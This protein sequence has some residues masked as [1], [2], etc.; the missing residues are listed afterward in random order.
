MVVLHESV[1]ETWKG[2]SLESVAAGSPQVQP[3]VGQ[4]ERADEVIMWSSPVYNVRHVPGLGTRCRPPKRTLVI[5]R[6]SGS[7]ANEV[8]PAF[9]RHFS[10]AFSNAIGQS[11]FSLRSDPFESSNSLAVPPQVPLFARTAFSSW[12]QADRNKSFAVLDS[13]ADSPLRPFSTASREF[14]FSATEAVGREASHG[15]A[16]RAAHSES[17]LLTSFEDVATL[18]ISHAAVERLQQIWA[19]R[20]FERKEGGRRI[21]EERGG[22]VLGLL[23]RVVSGG[24][25]GYKY[26]F[27]LVGPD[28][29]SALREGGEHVFFWPSFTSASGSAADPGPSTIR[30][31]GSSAVERDP[32]HD[33]FAKSNWC[34][35][36]DKCSV[37]FLVDAF[38]DYADSLAAS[39]FRVIRNAQAENVCSCGH[40]FAIRDD[41]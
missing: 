8:S 7:V 19:R 25:S 22:T 2:F 13:L 32:K 41:F 10:G 27:E 18:Q 39:E 26:C 12:V 35:V 14:R 40:S 21:G 36:V 28:E 3:C 11:P 37:P 31:E 34:V 29:L 23:V 20:H 30:R 33:F 6:V 24:C 9:A 15:K 16:S 38:V 17:F 1:K 5:R 4:A